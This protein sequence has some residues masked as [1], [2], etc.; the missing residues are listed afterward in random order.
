MSR[1]IPFFVLDSFT[2]EPFQGNP[3]GVFLVG[4]TP[5]TDSEMRKLA[6]EISL[7]SAFLLPGDSEAMYRVR[8]FTGVTEVPLCGHATVAALT[9]LVQTNQLALDQ[10]VTLRTNVGLLTSYLTLDNRANIQISL[11]QNVAEFHEPVSGQIT[12]EIAASLGYYPHEIG[13]DHHLLSVQ[14]VNTGTPWIFVPVRLRAVVDASPANLT[15][16]ADLSRELS[17]YGFYIFTLESN[18]GIG[19]QT[20]GRCFAP[21][22]GLNED[23]V[24]GSASG[25]LGCYLVRNGVL[26]P[27]RDDMGNRFATFTA[28]QGFAGGRGGSVRVSVAV[29]SD[30]KM[31]PTITGNAT[32][33]AQGNF[34]LP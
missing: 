10:T 2:E 5:V 27:R 32:L 33:V 22:A 3:A 34:T 4:D 18:P 11:T 20:W 26:T 21:V 6:G 1:T 25:A 16:V 8:Y 30:G 9:A 19:V 24:T 23:P 17:A 28:L 31:Q 29:D 14:W 13:S 15:A 12:E 7:E